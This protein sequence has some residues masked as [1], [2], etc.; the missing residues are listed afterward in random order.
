VAFEEGSVD[1][2][3][4]RAR[5]QPQPWASGRAPDGWGF[6][7]DF[8]VVPLAVDGWQTRVV[9]VFHETASRS[10]ALVRAVARDDPRAVLTATI[11]EAASVAA[12]HEVLLEELASS[13]ADLVAAGSRG[14][15]VGDVAFTDGSAEPRLVMMA[16][17]NLVVRVGSTG[18]RDVDPVPFATSVDRAIVMAYA[19]T[20]DRGGPLVDVFLLPA[21]IERDR[22]APIELSVR[23]RTPGPVARRL[24]SQAGPLDV[25]TGRLQLV[26]RREGAHALTLTAIAPDGAVVVA[27]AGIVVAA[28]P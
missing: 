22:P 1:L 6:W 7:L 12:A 23:T 27:R 25:A 2:A 28:A 11:V 21:R 17:D 4:Y 3:P 9:Q 26:A 8:H 20:P 18:P 15:D 24:Q 10:V 19:P 16:R 13:M 5:Y 14:I